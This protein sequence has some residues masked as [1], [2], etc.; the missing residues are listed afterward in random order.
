LSSSGRDEAVALAAGRER[1]CIC[2]GTSIAAVRNGT[3]RTT[4]RQL[5]LLQHARVDGGGRGA[6]RDKPNW[7]EFV[8][9]RNDYNLKG[10]G[11]D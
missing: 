8:A 2:G 7:F 5:I 1:R 6:V 3:D 9:W 4:D 11:C 10:E